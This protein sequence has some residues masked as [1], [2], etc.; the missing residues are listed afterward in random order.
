M[1]YGSKLQLFPFFQFLGCALFSLIGVEVLFLVLRVG[2]SFNASESSLHNVF[3]NQMFILQIANKL[4]FSKK[5][6]YV[7]AVPGVR[8]SVVG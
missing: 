7:I 5:K 8:K 3:S 1:L 6:K 2:R 4:G